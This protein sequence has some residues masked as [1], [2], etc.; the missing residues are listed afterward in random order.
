MYSF[1]DRQSVALYLPILV[2]HTNQILTGKYKV[3]VVVIDGVTVGHPCCSIHNCHIPL[4]SNRDRYC[5]DHQDA[6]GICAIVGCSSPVVPDSKTCSNEDHQKVEKTHIERGQSRFQLQERLSRARIAHPND[7]LGEAVMTID[8]LA[9]VDEEDEAFELPTGQTTASQAAHTSGSVDASKKKFRAQF[10]RK[11]T[12]N[13]QIIV[14]PCGMIHARETFFGAEAVSSVVVSLSYWCYCIILID[15]LKE[16]IKRTYRMP[17][18]LPDH[19][20][21]D[22]NCQLA[23]VVQDD[24]AFANV[25]LS[26]D[27]FHFKSKHK[28]TDIFCQTNCNP[29][30]FPEL[31][32]LGNKAW[33]FNSSI[34]E[35]TNAW[36]GGYHSMCREMLVD[37]YNFFLDEMILRRNRLTYNKLALACDQPKTFTVE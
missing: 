20:F 29:V 27:V 32:G 6:A 2:I 7:S 9:D 4:S 3:S 25:G 30:D 18:T 31:K 33:Y 35:Q 23:K 5:K 36:L 22:N 28:A 12:H 13:E 26:V 11:R 34:A 8:E 19:I 1:Y 16:M 17:G 24:P 21:F 14:A 10:G 15:F 37:K